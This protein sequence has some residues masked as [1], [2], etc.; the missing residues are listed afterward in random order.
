MRIEFMIYIYGAVCMSMIAFNAVYALLL[1]SSQPRLEKRRRRLSRAVDF[2][3]ARLRWGLPLDTRHLKYLQRKLRKVKNLTAFDQVLRPLF[4]SCD[5][6]PAAQT[7]L[8]RLQPVILDLAL[9]YQKR[10]N[11][12]AAYFSYFLSHYML[13][14]HMPIQ[15]LQEV[16]LDYINKDN[17]YCCVNALQA[18]CSFGSVSYIL[19]ALQLQDRSP[20]FV[21][22][23]ILTETLL[24]FTGDH[25]ALIAQ[26]W[27]HLPS[28]T[29]HTQLAL[30]NYIRFCT[31]DCKEEM[32][33]LL[34][35]PK[36][37]KEV[38][39]AAIRYFGRYP[40]QPALEPLLSFAAD[41]DPSHWEYATVSA[42]ALARYATPQA[43][44]TLKKALHSSNWY[45]RY[46]AAMSL[47]AQQV[48]YEEL[49]DIVAGNDRYAREIMTYRLESRSMQK[50][51]I[52]AT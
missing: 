43:V 8:V 41:G 46:A 25:E 31:G 10:E 24:S 5:A 4:Q 50:E 27:K 33:A 44:S 16:L 18:L 13:Q 42:S 29:P 45:V 28:F 38:R 2:Q 11:T 6:D 37:D 26:L 12:Q 34:E 39:L 9:T 15:S 1:R 32:L 23:K 51:S 14:K 48:P 52:G 21:H 36:Q 47:E 40:Y 22:E 30:L 49:M 19:A 7:Y 3:L 35:D 20:V 17:L